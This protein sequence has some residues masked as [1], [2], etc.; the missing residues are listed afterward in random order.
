MSKDKA[1]EYVANTHGLLSAVLK[2]YYPA[3]RL[4]TVLPAKRKPK[5]NM[6]SDEDISAIMETVKDSRNGHYF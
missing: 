1:A 3:F 5:H 2:E 6:P 4:S